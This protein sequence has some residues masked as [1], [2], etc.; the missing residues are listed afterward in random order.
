MDFIAALVIDE[1]DDSVYGAYQMKGIL[2]PEA[3]Q[4]IIRFAQKAIQGLSLV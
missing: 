2:D 3:L 4:K 1:G